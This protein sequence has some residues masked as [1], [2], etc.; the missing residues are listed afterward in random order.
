MPIKNILSTLIIRGF[1]LGIRIICYILLP[2]LISI[3]HFGVFAYLIALTEILKIICDFG[4]DSYSIKKFS[5]NSKYSRLI[6]TYSISFFQKTVILLVT[7]LLFNSYFIFVD[8][9]GISYTYIV[10]FSFFCVSQLLIN[11]PVSYSL[12]KGELGKCLVPVLVSSIF[13]LLLLSFSY[14]LK[15]P[16]MCLLS[17]L[18][19][20]LTIAAWL[21]IN[22][23]NLL[24][25]KYL[26]INFT[27]DNFKKHYSI[28]IAMLVAITSA[29]FDL[30]F[31]KT[32][33]GFTDMG[34]YSFAQRFID[35]GGFIAGAL[36]SNAYSWMSKK[37]S[38][39]LFQNYD[40]N[41]N[42]ILKVILI[43]LVFGIILSLGTLL[44]ARFYIIFYVE[45][46]I[47]SLPILYV[48]CLVL[49]FRCVNLSLSAALMT[50]SEFKKLMFI[51][52][53]LLFVTVLAVYTLSIH[54]SLLGIA[55][56]VLFAESV[57]SML[58]FACLRYCLK[59]K[60]TKSLSI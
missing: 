58:Q 30:F 39:N 8:D 5:E 52:T 48:F 41:K 24:K 37:V 7:V 55:F 6:K 19:G 47:I 36:A 35:V 14:H 26:K 23:I 11:L 56:G 29:K 60:Q 12:S 49:M 46:Y 54:F 21:N 51:N 40:E 4:L 50:L 3:E 32:H 43:F 15:M 45:K 34:V 2:N 10:I 53:F 18:I 38:G 17:V 20:E 13:S 1:S 16:M 31:I 59:I 33:F 57:N 44:V 25:R 42:Y 27:L 22:R 28:G 9:L